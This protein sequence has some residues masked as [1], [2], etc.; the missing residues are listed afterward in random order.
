MDNL[1]ELISQSKFD[2]AKK[3]ELVERYSPFIYN[4]VFKKLGTQDDDFLQVARLA[5]CEAIDSYTQVK[6]SFLKY[7]ELVMNNRMNDE[8]RKKYKNHEDYYFEESTEESYLHTESIRNYNEVRSKQ[9]C[10]E[11]IQ[12]YFSELL[13]WGFSIYNLEEYCPKHKDTRET[14]KF[15]A[16]VLYNNEELKKLI[17]CNRRLPVKRLAKA[18]MLKHR[19]LEK[20][21]RYIIMIFIALNGS[22]YIIREYIGGISDGK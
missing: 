4:I 22:Y 3:S 7:A 15:V 12:A 16:N 17:L 13:K 14:C 6:G 11:E 21:S 1:G 18:T 2:N 20:H 19:F 9:D 10:R 5:F 8:L